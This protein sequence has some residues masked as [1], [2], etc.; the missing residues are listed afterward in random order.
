[1]P[2]FQHKGGRIPARKYTLP[3]FQ[4]IPWG[5]AGEPGLR[6]EP[7]GAA[8]CGGRVG[9]G[10][11]GAPPT[12]PADRVRPRRGLETCVDL[13]ASENPEFVAIFFDSLSF[14]VRFRALEASVSPPLTMSRVLSDA[15]TCG[16]AKRHLRLGA[17]ERR[18]T[19]KN[20]K[21]SPRNPI[22][23]TQTY[24]Q[25]KKARGVGLLSPLLCQPRVPTRGGARKPGVPAVRT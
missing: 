8:T 19:S 13:L 21:K 6:A 17:A 14:R 16:F 2:D 18:E 7:A 24:P 22:W 4:H 1:M 25:P 9:G 12:R 15:L 10:A 11:R 23:L 3:D 5:A 20:R